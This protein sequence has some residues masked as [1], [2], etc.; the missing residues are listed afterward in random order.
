[1]YSGGEAERLLLFLPGLLP[2]KGRTDIIPASESESAAKS[3]LNRGRT[4]FGPEQLEIKGG[5][6]MKEISIGII[7]IGNMGS[8]HCRNL[9]AGKCPE[10]QPVAVADLREERLDWARENL[11]E[12]IRRYA[13]GQELIARDGC[14]AVL[15]A[16][17]H[18]LHAELAIAAME[19]G[20]H[21]LCEK[22]MAVT[23]R[24]AARMLE[25]AERTGKTLALMFNQRTNCI[26][27]AMREELQSGRMGAIKRVSWIITDW[28]RTQRYY[29]SGNWRAT[30]LGEGGGVLL[31]QCPHQLDLL[32]WLCGMP[33]AV[34][35]HCAEGKWHHIEVEDDVTAYLEFEGGA[36]GVF[37]ASTGDLPGTNRLEIDCENG[38]M[39]CENGKVHRIQLHQN[40]REVCFDSENPWYRDAGEDSV[41]PTDGENPQ[42]IGV[43]NAFA[44]HLLRGE[45]LIADAADGRKAI[46]LS[47]AIHLS[48]W[49]GEK[50]AIP[51]DEKRFQRL[52]EERIASSRI[53]D[54]AFLTY[55]T[56]HHGTGEMK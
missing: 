38:K 25:T 6:K 45:P 7:G 11:P 35:A 29:D 27:R 20:K 28:Y 43:L 19:A 4:R 52:L 36:T 16:V 18:P 56:S 30:W 9:V 51:A 53:K 49:T 41:L 21:V 15:I 55:E 24:D 31:N 44:A 39:V 5:T 14:D 33:S 26:Y 12:G 13:S 48:G 8:E 17:P 50:I 54:V 3:V 34:Q 23:A 47:N 46:Q 22:P 32:I 40:E 42:H 37:I 2:E 10:I 1:M